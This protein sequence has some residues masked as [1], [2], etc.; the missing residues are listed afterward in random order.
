[1]VVEEAN[2]LLQS[3]VTATR[4]QKMRKIASKENPIERHQAPSPESTDSLPN[5][6]EALRQVLSLSD[7]MHL[8]EKTARWVDP[9]TFEYLPVWYPE[10]ARRGLFYKANWSEPLMNKNRQT[11]VSVH[12]FEGNTHANKALTLAL[13]LRSDERRNWSCCHIWGVDDESY[14][15][16]NSVVQDRRFFSCVANMV[17]LPTPLKAFTDAMPEVKMMLRVCALHLYG[18]SCDHEDVK[19]FKKQAGEWHDWRHY[20]ESWPRPG[21]TS[22]PLGIARFSPRVRQAA[23]R[24]IIAIRKDLASAGQYYPRGE[25]QEVLAYWNITI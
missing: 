6:L 23:D 3:E 1:M 11:G 9:K 7:V 5:G 18:W 14:Q 21:K 17:L 20:P 2:Y 25:V 4:Q 10:H 22:V 8:I 24:R 13:G 16:S 19:N 12:K 15:S